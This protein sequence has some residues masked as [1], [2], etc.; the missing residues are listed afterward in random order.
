MEGVRKEEREIF[1]EREGRKIEEE[2]FLDEDKYKVL[3]GSRTMH[4]NIML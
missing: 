3:V 4:R 2:R 1:V